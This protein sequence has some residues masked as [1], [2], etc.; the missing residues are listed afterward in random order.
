MTN[1][2]PKSSEWFHSL[3]LAGARVRAEDDILERLRAASEPDP[4]HY[5]GFDLS[6]AVFNIKDAMHKRDLIDGLS[7]DEIGADT[8]LQID[9]T[10]ETLH[11][12]G[13]QVYAALGSTNAM[14]VFAKTYVRRDRLRDV[15]HSWDGIGDWVA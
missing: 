3:Q 14:I 11:N 15:D 10:T 4:R 9:K 13:K 8:E 6:E 2:T 1:K 7:N 12:A 5:L